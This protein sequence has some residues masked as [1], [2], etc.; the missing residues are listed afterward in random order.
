M[1]RSYLRANYYDEL[2]TRK[3]LPLRTIYMTNGASGFLLCIWVTASNLPHFSLIVTH[4][5][6]DAIFSSIFNKRELL[7]GSTQDDILSRDTEVLY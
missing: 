5:Q 4:Q 7:A 6:L 3:M 2:L 1:Q